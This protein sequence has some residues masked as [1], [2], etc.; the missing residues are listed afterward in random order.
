MSPLPSQPE[1]SP[2]A[3]MEYLR[4]IAA[5]AAHENK[6]SLEHLQ[7]FVALRPKS[8]IGYREL[9]GQLYALHRTDE[10]QN[11]YAKAIQI[12][13]SLI[14]ARV[15]YGQLLQ[16]R[17]YPGAA[18]EHLRYAWEQG[19]GSTA[20]VIPLCNLLR[21]QH[22]DSERL[23]LLNEAVIRNPWDSNLW[24]YFGQ[25][26]QASLDHAGAAGA[27]ARSADL[28]PENEIVRLH[29]AEEFE[30]AGKNTQAAE[31]YH[32]LAAQHDQSAAAHYF[33]ARFLARNDAR[34][35]EAI[36]QAQLALALSAHQSA[37]PR[38]TIEAL[39]SA[40]RAGRAGDASDFRL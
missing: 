33:L 17:L 2:S 36:R 25:S 12:D 35:D 3:T 10:S 22:K 37:P 32:L 8:A 39:I 20:A 40:I 16:E 18:E 31:Q 7:A 21:E 13:P 4:G 14:S 6:L 29:A 27:F 34:R 26:K 1:E 19:R 38:A 24:N 15:L 9:A 23:K 5:S 30:S 28:M 11:A